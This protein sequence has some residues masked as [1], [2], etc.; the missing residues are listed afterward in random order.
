MRKVYSMEFVWVNGSMSWFWIKAE[1]RNIHIDPSYYPKGQVHGPEMEQKA[2]L[3]L[4]THSHP[5]HFQKKTVELLK[6]D[7]TIVIAPSKVA[8][9]R[10]P[11]KTTIAELGK[12]E[13]L[14]WAK[15]KPVYAYN[16]GLKGHIFHKKG[17]CVGYLLTVGGKTIYHAGDTEFIPEMRELGHVD[18]ALLPIGGT[19]T[20]DADAAAEAARAIGAKHVVPMHN[21]SK[22][23]SEL[24]T[25][26]QNDLNIDVVLAEKGK[27]FDPF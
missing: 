22:P 16:L 10:A 15:V 8:Q 4:I 5:D 27:A 18:L 2:D 23:T 21:R 7:G 24:K 1:G 3:I 19:V 12:E 11:S 14:G 17:A 9:K 25:K 20:M 26:L 6:G 13:D